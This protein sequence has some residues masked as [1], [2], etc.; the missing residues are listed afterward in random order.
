RLLLFMAGPL[1]VLIENYQAPLGLD[2]SLIG[3]GFKALRVNNRFSIVGFA[4]HQKPTLAENN[5]NA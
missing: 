2:D 1:C 4:K 3:N 5:N